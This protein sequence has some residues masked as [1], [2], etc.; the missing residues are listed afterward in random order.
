MRLFLDYGCVACHQGMNIGTNLYQK[1]GVMVPYAD[2]EGAPDGLDRY[3]VTGRQ[4]DI[5]RVRVPSLRNVAL[6]N[7]YLH[8][9][10][11]AKLA[12]VVEIMFRYPLGREPAPRDIRLIV[13]FLKTLTGKPPA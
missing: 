4:E 6:T 13:K 7:P 11:V 8:D 2:S 3:D 12:D 10:S 9:G 5:R 1:L